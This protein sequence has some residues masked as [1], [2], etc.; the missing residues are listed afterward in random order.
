MNTE[1]AEEID[2][3]LIQE[4]ILDPLKDAEE[5]KTKLYER[6]MLLPGEFSKGTTD[7]KFEDDL[8]VLENETMSQYVYIEFSKLKLLKFRGVNEGDIL[9]IKCWVAKRLL[10]SFDEKRNVGNYKTAK[11]R[12]NALVSFIKETNNFSNDFIDDKKGLG[13]KWY[14]DSFNTGDKAI[15]EKAYAVM[16]F[17]YSSEDHFLER[18]GVTGTV[19]MENIRNYMNGLKVKT[20]SRELPRTRDILLFDYYVKKFFYNDDTVKADDKILYY[21]ILLWWRITN[22]IPMRPSE[23]CFK[24]PRDCLIKENDNYYIR[25]GRIKQKAEYKRRL[26]PVLD[27][28]KITKDIY[29]LIRDYIDK[30]D[31]KKYGHS[32]TLISYRALL[33]FKK[34]EDYDRKINKDRFSLAILEELLHRFSSQI[35][36]KKYEEFSIK[37]MVKPGD[38]RHFAFTSLLLQGV[39]PPYIAIMGGHRSLRTLDNYTCSSSYYADSEI[40][41][42]VNTMLINNKKDDVDN[43]TIMDIVSNM[44]QKCPK[45]INLCIPMYDVGFC[46]ANF[47][48]DGYCC[49]DETFCFKCSKWWCEPSI[50]NVKKI[51]EKVKNEEIKPRREIYEQNVEFLLDLFRNIGLEFVNGD[52]VVNEDDYRE[53]KRMALNIK[54]D[55]ES[56]SSDIVMSDNTKITPSIDGEKDILYLENALTLLS[57]NAS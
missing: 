13:I 35:I 30:T 33:H 49:E 31:C 43:E 45:D 57:D 48:E 3:D 54:S 9:V 51:I 11:T 23:F 47:D 21:P 5:L 28:L 25:I 39:A 53:L 38:T 42:Y 22:I 24:I 27:R 18:H 32:E 55:I 20:K 34:M 19:Y 2:I 50:R 7:G 29:E 16:D 44:P 4:E 26:L 12:Y 15:Y 1:I 14:F 37:R 46:M 8:W 6:K 41:K 10:D 40:V 56:I 17:I 36:K 52:L